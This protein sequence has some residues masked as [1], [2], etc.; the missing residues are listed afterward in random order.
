MGITGT[1]TRQRWH[2]QWRRL[3]HSLDL[4]PEQVRAPAWARETPLTEH[5]PGGDGSVTSW[6]RARTL[7]CLAW[8]LCECCRGEREVRNRCPFLDP[9]L[10]P[11]LGPHVQK[12]LRGVTTGG[13]ER[14]P[15]FGP[16]VWQIYSFARYGRSRWC[17]VQ[18]AFL[19]EA[20]CQTSGRGMQ[21][22]YVLCRPC[23]D[24]VEHG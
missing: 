21:L 23:T 14:G 17:T 20:L 5:C 18:C 6:A 3:L 4:F 1:L 7:A 10:V 11:T 9:L 12:V 8:G 15:N 24:R 22:A 2:M 19:W 16:T 13:P